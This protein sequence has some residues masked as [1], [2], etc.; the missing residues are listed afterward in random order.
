MSARSLSKPRVPPAQTGFRRRDAGAAPDPCPALRLIKKP[1]HLHRRARPRQIR[2]NCPQTANSPDAHGTFCPPIT[3]G[4]MPAL[5]FQ[6]LFA[7]YPFFAFSE[8]PF[9]IPSKARDLLFPR[10]RV[11]QVPHLW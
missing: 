5:S 1:T 7:R 2:A 11:P 8:L 3:G 9:V 4:W 10:V 6:V